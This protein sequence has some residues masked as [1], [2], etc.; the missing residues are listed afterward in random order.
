MNTPTIETDSGKAP[1]VKRIKFELKPDG[2]VERVGLFGSYGPVIEAQT[3]TEATAALLRFAF[4]ALENQPRVKIQNGAAQ[5]AYEA[6]NG[7]NV[8]SWIEGRAFG[9][10]FS[11]ASDW[12]ALND[13]LASFDYYASEAYRSAAQ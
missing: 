12:S 8:E 13:S 3:K 9:L 10:C 11:G 5:L 6:I 7:I 2:S 4:R 1:S